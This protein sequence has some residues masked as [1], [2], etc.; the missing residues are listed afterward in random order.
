MVAGRQRRRVATRRSRVSSLPTPLRPLASVAVECYASRNGNAR[1][2][3]HS[4]RRFN[5]PPVTESEA[6]LTQLAS[7]A[8]LRFWSFPNVFMKE[9][10][11]L[12][13]LLVAF[14]NDLLIFSDKH[15]DL[16]DSKPR[17]LAWARWHRRAV[18]SSARQA[19]GA[20]RW[21]L[22]HPNRVFLDPGCKRPIHLDISPTAR[23]HHVLT[24]RG[25]AA[26]AR[27][28]WG[29]RG[30]LMITNLGLDECATTPFRL[31]SFDS[32]G[33][34]VHIFD[35]VALDAVLQTLDTAPDRK[36]TRLNSS[37]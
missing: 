36:S 6:Y 7:R 25:A 22:K 4:H 17:D 37:H 5:V 34:F 2:L 21:L 13:D 9:G 19:V 33:T 14:G 3:R 35:E 8:F 12:C 28:E 10:K 31:G 26:A 1:T 27:T 15:C 23:A 18:E 30:S 29:G 32:R 16:D 20:S 11:E 24:V